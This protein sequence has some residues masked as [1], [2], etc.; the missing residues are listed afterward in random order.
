MSSYL[1]LIEASTLLSALPHDQILEFI[2]NGQFKII[3]YVKNRVIHFEG[4]G[5]DQIEIILAGKVVIDR[6]DESGNLLTITE[7]YPD[8]LLGGNLVF[9]KNSHYPWTVTTQ[10]PSILLQIK[11]SLLIELCFS[12]R[13]FLIRYL[14]FISDHALLL[15]DKI[16]HYVNRS[17]RESL[18]SFLKYEA[19]KQNVA[20]IQLECTKKALAEKMGI[21]RTSLSRALQKMKNDGLILFD[22]KTIT[23]LDKSIIK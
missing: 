14:E 13:D 4:E 17:I 2:S 6:I 15:G 10:Q 5:C 1:P 22:E 16:K 8:D 21:Q 9:S 3:N 19:K 11:K 20:Q 23:I 7:L 12:N 18:I